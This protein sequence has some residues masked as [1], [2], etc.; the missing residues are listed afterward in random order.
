[1]GA[2]GHSSS[3][4]DSLFSPSQL[5]ALRNLRIGSM[6]VQHSRIQL[7]KYQQGSSDVRK[8][9]SV[10][11][12][13]ENAWIPSKEVTTRATKLEADENW[14]LVDLLS[15]SASAKS[16]RRSKSSKSLLVASDTHRSQGNPEAEGVK[17]NVPSF[18]QSGTNRGGARLWRR[19]DLRLSKGLPLNESHEDTDAET[20]DNCEE[21][22]YNCRMSSG[23]SISWAEDV[24]NEL[25]DFLNFQI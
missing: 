5:P 16:D 9:E 24:R 6:R 18:L 13:E 10:F 3:Q 21:S 11:G 22:E 12:T 14:S 20:D 23:S 8:T 2:E 17:R 1:M 15:R 19:H 7:Y 25:L 4:I